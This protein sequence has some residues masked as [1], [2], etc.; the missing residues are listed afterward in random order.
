MSD[1][2][3]LVSIIS[4]DHQDFGTASGDTFDEMLSDV[5][6]RGAE[7][8]EKANHWFPFRDEEITALRKGLFAALTEINDFQL[9]HFL[10]ELDTEMARRQESP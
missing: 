5:I 8:G 3:W 1:K 9:E 2:R 4:R 6:R 10:G 7:V